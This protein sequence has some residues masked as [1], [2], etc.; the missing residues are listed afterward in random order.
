MKPLTLRERRWTLL[1]FALRWSL[2]PPLWVLAVVLYF[3]ARGIVA[4]FDAFGDRMGSLQVKWHNR[5]LARKRGMARR[6]GEARPDGW[7]P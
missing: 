1:W 7:L 6:P 4:A 5:D 2:T 3:P